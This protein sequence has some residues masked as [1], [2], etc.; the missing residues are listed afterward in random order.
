LGQLREPIKAKNRAQI[1]IVTKCPIDI[2]PIELRIITK[3]LHL[4]PYQTLYFTTLAY[5]E[6]VPVFPEKKQKK[7]TKN[8]LKKGNYT[9]LALSGIASPEPFEQYLSNYATKLES[10]RF[11]DHHHFSRKDLG[12]IEKKFNSITDPDKIIITTEKDATRLKSSSDFPPS[13]KS[14]IYYIPLT[15]SFMLEQEKSFNKQIY[16]YVGRRKQNLHIH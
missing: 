5:G 16:D 4:Y 9:V 15:I 13:L 6:L 8:Q 2:K 14:Q 12:E 3:S 10:L 7:V 11:P 1:V